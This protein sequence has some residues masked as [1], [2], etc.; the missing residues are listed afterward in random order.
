[1]HFLHICSQF[2]AKCSKKAPNSLKTLDLALQIA[3]MR[4]KCSKNRP[5]GH[6][7]LVQHPANEHVL[8][9]IRSNTLEKR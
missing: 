6:P 5:R 1:M 8:D 2:D 9:H 4:K 3:E 7:K